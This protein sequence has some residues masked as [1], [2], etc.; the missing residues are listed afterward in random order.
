[1]RAFHLL[2]F[3]GL[4]FAGVAAV[5]VCVGV[6]FAQ[7]EIAESNIENGDVLDEP[8][9]VIELCFSE[10]V[11]T[12][13]QPVEDEDVPE[14]WRF[15]ITMPDE[16]ALGLRIVFQTDGECVDVEPGIPDE[17]PEGVW[18]FDWMVRSRDTGE[19]S[20]GTMV[21]RVGAG[22]PPELPGASD[23]GG[24]DVWLI[25]GIAVGAAALIALAGYTGYRVVER[26][27]SGQA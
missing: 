26:R 9:S 21:F 6:V 16:R 24:D 15:S 13:D 10:P 4:A 2:R 5:I 1:M 8:P 19:P 7:P 17:A 25:V 20:S 11:N 27:R 12:D 14:P 23:D 3:T 22:E 18:T